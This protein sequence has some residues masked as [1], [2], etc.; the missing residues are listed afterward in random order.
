MAA[1]DASILATGDG[2]PAGGARWERRAARREA[3]R[4]RMPKHGQRY[5]QLAQRML[6]RRAAEVKAAALRPS[7]R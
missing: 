7:G 1:T 3:A 6:A 4:R 5:A 2:A